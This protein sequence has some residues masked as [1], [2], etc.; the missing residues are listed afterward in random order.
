MKVFDRKIFLWL[1]QHWRIFLWLDQP[2]IFQW[3]DQHWKIFLWLDQ[4]SPFHHQKINSPFHH[5]KMENRNS[6]FHHK[7]VENINSPFHHRKMEKRIS[8]FQILSHWH[9][10]QNFQRKMKK[11]TYQGIRTQTHNCQTSH[12]RK[13]NAIRR[14]SVVKKERWLVR[15][16]IKR[17]FWFVRRQWL[18]TQAT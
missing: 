18:Q 4:I 8:P 5:G 16:I 1:D 12:Q 9:N 6:P 3:L 10:Q 7:K 2:W 13:R 17:R 15:P 11:G 14:K